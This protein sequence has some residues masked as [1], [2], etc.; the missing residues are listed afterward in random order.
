MKLVSKAILAALAA[1][2]LCGCGRIAPQLVE[3]TTAPKVERIAQ[4]VTEQS[5][6]ELEQNYPDLLEADFTGSECYDAIEA[7]A[8]RNP[9]V[10]VRYLVRLGSTAAEPDATAL[11]LTPSDFDYEILRQNLRHLPRLQS[12]YLKQ[13]KLSMEEIET[14]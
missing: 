7:Y 3:T 13:S 5:L 4:V 1:V 10:R 8:A 6:L 11:E 12:L 2:L 9:Q 14:L